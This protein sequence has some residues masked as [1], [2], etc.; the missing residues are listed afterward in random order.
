MKLE[1]LRQTKLKLEPLFTVKKTGEKITGQFLDS[2]DVTGII[3]AAQATVDAT[4]LTAPR[5]TLLN[6]QQSSVIVAQQQAYVSG[7]T[8]A[9]AGQ[10]RKE[11]ISTAQT[12]VSVDV[13]ASVN[14]NRKYIT[15]AI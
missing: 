12:G 8:E 13:M 14:G 3:R 5:M 1:L 10:K 9:V 6:G 11:Q 7:W 15:L 4:V 2:D